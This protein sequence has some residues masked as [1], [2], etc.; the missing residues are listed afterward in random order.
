MAD[1]SEV[2]VITL[3][4]KGS[5]LSSSSVY[6]IAHGF[7]LVRIDS[8][9][10]ERLS[11]SSNSRNAAST[12]HQVFIPNFLT[13]EEARASLAVLLNKL[14]ISSSSGI[15]S[16]IPVL[17]A[18]TLNS[19][20]ETLQFESLDVTDEELSVF[21]QSCYVLNGICALLDHQSAALS[22]IADAVAAISCE[23]SRADVSAFGLMDSGDG[24]AS[25][26]EVGVANDM[27]VLLN[28]SKLVGKIESGAFSK[29]PKNHG[30]LREQAKLVHSKMRVELNSCMKFGKGGSLSSGIEDSVRTA[31]LSFAAVLWD[32]GKCS[33]YRG[34]LILSSNSNEN[35]KA[36][37]VGLLDRECP[38]NESLKKEY[39]LVSELALDDQYDEFVHTVNVLLVTV[40][41][42]VAWEAIAAF[43][44]IEGGELLG[45]GQD[46]DINEVNEKVVKKNEKKK[47]AVLGKGT[48]VVVQ[49]IK[50]R[51]QGKGG[52][53]SAGGL[54]SLE[55]SVKD[56]LSFLDPKASE[57][58]N[59][60][61]KIKEIVESNESRR[62]PKL[63]KVM[64]YFRALPKFLV[65]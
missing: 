40:W 39:K 18:E 56:L 62:L 60:L 55:N 59:L 22:S 24:F 30:C 31:L 19:K 34:K 28:G 2:S 3:G 53:A 15:R 50:D 16:V 1:P 63:P 43:L 36:S 12:K 29:I 4:G 20:P 64:T 27:K 25:K 26:E 23:A 11:S 5:S 47:K 17:I 14:I 33:L 49:L 61:K 44:T 13:R 9:A 58:D 46:V 65:I 32:L 42:I 7:A 35:V 54:G 45:K 37:L 51:L 10:L 38:S 8:S 52:G 57:F 21:K 41:K 6:A 48:S